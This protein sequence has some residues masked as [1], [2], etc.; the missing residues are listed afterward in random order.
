MAATKFYSTDGGDFFQVIRETKTTVTVRP[1]NSEYLETTAIY[2]AFDYDV[3]RRAIANDFT[4]SFLF[5]D[6]QNANGKRCK[7]NATGNGGIIL[8]NYYGA[9]AW[10]CDEVDTFNRDFR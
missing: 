5:T 1:V 8:S 7:K 6:A 10:P 3:K 2:T 9:C 4:T